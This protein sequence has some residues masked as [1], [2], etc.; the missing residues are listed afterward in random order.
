MKTMKLFLTVLVAS[1][2]GKR[3]IKEEDRGKILKS[4]AN[5]AADILIEKGAKDLI[6]EVKKELEGE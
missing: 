3:F 5:H 6:D 1:P 2:D 4:L